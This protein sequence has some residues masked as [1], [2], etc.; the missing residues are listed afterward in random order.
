VTL[1]YLH[2]GEVSTCFAESKSDLMFYDAGNR[3]RIMGH[4]HGAIAKECGSSGIV[5]GR[6]K[7]AA[8][9]LDETDA[10]WLLWIDSDM[11]FAPD[12][13]DR[14]LEV[15]DPTERP[16]VGGLCFAMRSDGKA[17]FFGTKHRC[18]PTVYDFYEE[19]ERVGF[20]SRMDYE[21]DAVVPV[22]GTG[23]AFVLIHRTALER[24][25]TK[26][27]DNWYTPIT[28]PT[29]PTTFSEDLSFCV[30]AA[31]TDSPTFVHT[32]VKTTHHKGF[33]YLD[34]EFYTAQEV[35]AGRLKFS[36]APA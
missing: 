5:D 13:L 25:R 36:D 34:E 4:P 7:V 35:A 19:S 22:A 2:P 8:A 21:R 23:S 16:I 29:G 15:A 26:H 11:G 1:A 9:F 20:I 10:D 17:S 31:A 24:V 12:S 32:G 14:L 28:H 18:V 30:R 27:G 6:N 33:S 3:R